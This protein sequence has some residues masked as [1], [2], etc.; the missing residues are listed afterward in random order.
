MSITVRDVMDAMEA[1][2]PLNWAYDWDKAGLA[3]GAPDLHVS[4]VLC[5]LTLTREAFRAARRA[6]AELIVSHHPLIWEP[7]EALRTD[8]PHTRLCLD[9]AEAKM[10]AYSAHTNLD[11]APG[12]VN[13]V[14]A[15][16]LG[17]Q[18]TRPLLPL[19]HT[20]LVKLICFVPETHLAALREAVSEAGA[21]HIGAYSECSFS[22]PGT[23]TFKPDAT[24]NPYAGTRSRLNFEPEHRFETIV[25]KAAMSRV[26]AAM[27]QAHP[28]EEPAY[29][30]VPL[31][32]GDPR[33][34]LGMR[35]VLAKPMTLARFANH[36]CAALDCKDVR[37][38]GAAK[39]QIKNAAV[40]GG[41]GGGEL[42]KIPGDIDVCV[43]GD[44]K[45]HDALDALERG[46]AVIDAGHRGTEHLIVPKIARYLRGAVP[47][48]RTSTYQEPEIFITAGPEKGKGK[49]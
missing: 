43:T 20:S 36:V 11:V 32:M 18:E 28:Y 49:R 22:T 24:A 30:L 31:D 26:V 1:W 42:G 46:L 37:V 40:L 12:G 33:L 34:G 2:A 21:G 47:G 38:V 4:R 5:C 23:G 8:Q 25:P 16:K 10:A 13:A 29:D 9:V 39:K 27:Y 45:Y 44:V 19:E 48:L 6:K 17:L 14:L 15:E 7:L 35:G 3:I 41:A